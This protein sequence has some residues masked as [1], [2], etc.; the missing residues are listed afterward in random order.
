MNK[1][2]VERLYNRLIEGNIPYF[3]YNVPHE[4]ILLEQKSTIH[5]YAGS[6]NPIHDMHRLIFE[7]LKGYAEKEAICAYEISV[8]RKQKEFLPFDELYKRLR[9]FNKNEPVIVTKEDSFVKKTGAICGGD[10]F[11]RVVFHIG[12]DTSMRLIEDDTFNGVQGINARFVVY[13]RDGVS[14]YSEEWW[15]RCPIPR[16]FYEGKYKGKNYD[17]TCKY[18]NGVSSTAIRGSN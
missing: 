1:K 16:N 2:N 11:K 10:V 18:V 8:N 3:A 12:Y 13:P 9:Q 4:N 14:L 15:D 6:F 17:M 5:V 7:C